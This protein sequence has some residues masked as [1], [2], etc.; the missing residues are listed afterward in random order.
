MHFSFS[1]LAQANGQIFIGKPNIVP[2]KVFTRI[3][4]SCHDVYSSQTA[5]HQT[6]CRQSLG[7]QRLCL[8]ADGEHLQKLQH[9]DKQ[10][11]NKNYKDV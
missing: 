3:D 9:I 11:S 5:M 10:R 7:A 1:G 8:Q 4:P 2:R 6:R